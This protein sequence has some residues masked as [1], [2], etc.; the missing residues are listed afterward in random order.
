MNLSLKVGSTLPHEGTHGNGLATPLSITYDA[1]CTFVTE[2]ILQQISNGVKSEY[3]I[4]VPVEKMMNWIQI[5][6]INHTNHINHARGPVASTL[7]VPRSESDKGSNGS[8][9]T[10]PYHFRGTGMATAP[11]P[12]TKPTRGRKKHND[13]NGPTC[14]YV[15]KRNTREGEVCKAH[16][17][18]HDDGLPYCNN[19]RKKAAVKQEIAA[20]LRHREGIESPARNGN[21][22]IREEEINQELDDG[23]AI[24]VSNYSPRPGYYIEDQDNF[25][26]K[27]LPDKRVLAYKRLG[28]DGEH[29]LTE[30]D[31]KL[32][33]SRNLST[34]INVEKNK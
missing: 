10:I 5:P 19:C 25:I 4:D 30:E 21:P 1:F 31:I 20:A 18:P 15:F 27:V 11:N 17:E 16:V 26:V 24:N 33:H 28:P 23:P 29:D 3:Q 2:T 22:K 9:A 32:A 8:M 13:I 7:P 6:V 34:M 14:I 12:K